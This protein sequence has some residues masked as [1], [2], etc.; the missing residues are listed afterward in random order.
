MTRSFNFGSEFPISGYGYKCVPAF[1]FFGFWRNRSLY[2][3]NPHQRRRTFGWLK[4]SAVEGSK[5]R[6][7]CNGKKNW[8]VVKSSVVWNIT[9]LSDESQPTF[10]SNVSPPYSMF[11]KEPRKKPA[12]SSQQAGRIIYLLD[13]CFRWATRRYIPEDRNLHNYRCENLESNL[14]QW[15]L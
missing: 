15:D 9:L 12:W 14:I 2:T 13:S 4:I 6:K 1:L 10:R 7:G 8:S 3:L 11:E 5:S